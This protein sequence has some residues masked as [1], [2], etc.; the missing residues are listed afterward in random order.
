VYLYRKDGAQKR[1]TLGTIDTMN[2]AEAH[3]AY[4]SARLQVKNGGDP[5]AEKQGEIQAEKAADTVN[6]LAS[7][8]MR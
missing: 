2:L 4:E 5:A 6:Q 7:E 1:L 3:A 8:Y